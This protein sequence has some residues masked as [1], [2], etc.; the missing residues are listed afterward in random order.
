MLSLFSFSF[1][2]WEMRVYYY[3]SNKTDRIPQK[4]QEERHTV[5]HLVAQKLHLEQ[6]Y[7]VFS[8]FDW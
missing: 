4:T 2:K 8:T 3:Y 1:Y 6:F 5:R 7:G